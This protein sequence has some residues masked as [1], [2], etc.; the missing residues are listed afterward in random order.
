M[1]FTKNKNQNPV[2]KKIKLSNFSFKQ[3]FINL[4]K[5]IKIQRS[6]LIVT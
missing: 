5:K 3:K 4:K 6:L 2:N 1:K